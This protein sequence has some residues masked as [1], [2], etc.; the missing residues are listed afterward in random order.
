V[1]VY[2]DPQAPENSALIPGADEFGNLFAIWGGSVVSVLIAWLVFRT[3]R[4]FP[5]AIANARAAEARSR[6]R[7]RRSA[8]LPHAFVSYEP[9]LKRKS[10]EPARDINACHTS[11]KAAG[12]KPEQS[13]KNQSSTRSCISC[14]FR[15]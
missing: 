12:H 2:Y 3:R 15:Y 8:G 9:G 10:E 6:L 4:F 11:H 14:L 13:K 7:P 1:D 5:Q